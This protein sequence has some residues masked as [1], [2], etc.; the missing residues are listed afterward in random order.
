M[1]ERSSTKR[2]R[3]LNQLAASI[4][5]AATAEEPEESAPVAF[6]TDVH[7]HAVELGKLGGKKGGPARAAKLTAEQRKEIARRAAEARWKK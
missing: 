7:A 2:G 4:V 3:D 5:N 6:E 1:R